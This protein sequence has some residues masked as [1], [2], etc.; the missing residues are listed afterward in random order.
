[1]QGLTLARGNR[2]LL[3]VAALAGLA[4]AILFVVAVNQDGSTTGTTAGAGTAKAVVADQSIAAGEEIKKNMVT[5]RE[6]IPESLLVAGAFS[7]TVNVVG[8]RATVAIAAG[9]QINDAKIG[10]SAETGESV[11]WVLPDGLRAVGLQVSE[12]TAV[13]GLLIPT[14]HVDIIGAFKI[15]GVPGLAENQHIL[16][17]RTILQNVEVLAVAQEKEVARSVASDDKDGDGA[18]DSL[19]SGDAPEDVETQPGA[20]TVT[21][22]LNPQQVQELIAA[23]AT[24]QTVWS[25]L[26][27][28][29]DSDPVDVPIYE[30]VVTE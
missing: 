29:G 14:D 24:A 3:I 22:A 4:A 26:R 7:D 19:A 17:V 8:E 23:Q 30:I 6:D 18:P 15:K 12:V 10:P 25:S 1:M 27:P 2:G 13:G 11:G 21:L 16:S 5:V 28:A 9:E 20:Q